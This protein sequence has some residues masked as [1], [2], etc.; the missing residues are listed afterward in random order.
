MFYISEHFLSLQGEGR[1]AGVP[2]YFLRTAGCNMRC[3]GFGTRYEVG[4]EQRSGCD[5]FFSVDPSF[6]PEW[7]QVNSLDFIQS[8][9]LLEKVQDVV[10]TGGEPLIYFDDEVFYQTICYLQSQGKTITFETNATIDV[11]FAKYSAYKDCIFSLSIKLS[12]SGE[13]Y[14]KRVKKEV[15]QSYIV[16]SKECFFKFTIDKSCV[17]SDAKEQI[18]DVV[19]G[20]DIDIYCMPVGANREQIWQNDKAV[21][22][23][24]IHNGF[25]YSDRLHIRVFD[26]TKGV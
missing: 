9:P 21:F 18:E 25:R 15:I 13:S 4:K 16:N 10:I 24:C 11:D 26:D 7:M 20:S 19:S 23:F 6:K 8:L 5:T 14:E 2:S 12:N 22:E 1:Y 17:Q 3:S